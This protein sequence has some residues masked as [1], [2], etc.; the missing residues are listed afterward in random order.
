MFSLKEQAKE[1]EEEHDVGQEEEQEVGQE[2]KQ[3]VCFCY[4]IVLCHK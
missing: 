1:H 2:E 4:Q 3:E